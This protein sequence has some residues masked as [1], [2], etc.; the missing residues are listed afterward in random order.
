MQYE[1]FRNGTLVRTQSGISFYDS[2]R[3]ENSGASYDIIAVRLDGSR[4]SASSIVLPAL[5]GDNDNGGGNNPDAPAAP[6]SLCVVRYSFKDAELFW[7]RAT[8]PLLQYE[9]KRDG[10]VLRSAFFGT[11]HF[12]TALS[13]D[14]AANYEV[15][16]IAPDGSRSPA[17]TVQLPGINAGNTTPSP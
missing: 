10:L 11:S 3:P 13:P 1:V 9:V 8:N 2:R 16:A 15:I 5:G 6:A 17:S 12:D 7:D 14:A 4:S